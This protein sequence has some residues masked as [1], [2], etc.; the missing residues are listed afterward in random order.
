MSVA[1]G[2]RLGVGLGDA[3][4]GEDIFFEHVEPA[5]D[6][7]TKRADVAVANRQSFNKTPVHGL[8]MVEWGLGLGDL[9]FAGGEAK[10]SGPLADPPGRERL[11]APPITPDRLEH[12]AAGGDLGELLIDRRGEPVESN[13]HHIEAPC[14]H[15]AASERVDDL[16]ATCGTDLEGHVAALVM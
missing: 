15:G 14:G 13:G 16:V 4:R 9:Q 5:V 2:K 1:A 6:D 10:A 12:G 7:R 11:A 3:T 8:K